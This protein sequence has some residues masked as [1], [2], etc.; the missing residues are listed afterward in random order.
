MYIPVYAKSCTIHG[1]TVGELK[2]FENYSYS[3]TTLTEVENNF[4]LETV[5]LETLMLD[6]FRKEHVKTCR[7]EL[8]KC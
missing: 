5:K 2:H 3:L 6:C 1:G 4:K 7:F 8:S